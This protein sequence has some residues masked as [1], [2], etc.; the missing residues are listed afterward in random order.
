M[1]GVKPQ[2]RQVAVFGQRIVEDFRDRTRATLKHGALIAQRR[3]LLD[4]VRHEHHGQIEFA[5][6]PEQFGLKCQPELRI[7]RAKRFVE[8]KRFRLAASSRASA[9][10]LRIPPEIWLG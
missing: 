9:Q 8:Q 6:D 3:C 2:P 5:A 7:E 4:V 10:R 1:P